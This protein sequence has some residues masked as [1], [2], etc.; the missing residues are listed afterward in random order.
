MIWRNLHPI[1]NTCWDIVVGERKYKIPDLHHFFT[2]DKNPPCCWCN[3]PS[4]GSWWKMPRIEV[5]C[6][7]L[8]G[9]HAQHAV[10]VN[11]TEMKNKYRE[12]QEVLDLIN[13]A[14]GLQSELAELE[15]RQTKER[16]TA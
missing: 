13:I 9:F 12:D 5:P 8:F 16:K 15:E 10:I 3:S 14:K 1:C 2:Y 7:G 6:N 4:H 11:L